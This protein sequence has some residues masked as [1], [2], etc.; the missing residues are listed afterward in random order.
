MPTPTKHIRLT[1]DGSPII[2]QD[3]SSSDKR[4]E[5][6]PGPAVEH[7]E[8]QRR[9]AGRAPRPR[10]PAARFNRSDSLSVETLKELTDAPNAVRNEVSRRQNNVNRAAD[11]RG[12]VASLRDDFRPGGALVPE[13]NRP[14]RWRL[15]AGS[16]VVDLAN[17]PGVSRA[18]TGGVVGPL[19]FIS[20]MVSSLAWPALVLVLVLIMRKP[21]KDLFSN[22]RR[23]KSFAAGATG[24]RIEYALE[25]AQTELAKAQVERPPLLPPPSVD[26]S[27][28]AQQGPLYE[29]SPPAAVLESFARLE[30]ALRQA[31][32]EHPSY[33]SGGS[34]PRSTRQ[35]IR[36]AVQLD[37]LSEPEGKAFEELAQIRNYTAHGE[38]EEITEGAAQRFTEI[39]ADL[40]ASISAWRSAHPPLRDND[41]HV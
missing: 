17:L 18:N 41:S 15:G 21:L 3:D 6:H 16:A 20:S 27:P 39:A 38:A 36:R 8:P 4:H 32:R 22:D 19:Q 40:M 12:I 35:L 13:D 33:L 24:L 34:Q 37:V 23:M 28:P 30:Q 10:A 11:A 26:A 14:S 2:T 29:V 7:H 1:A 5:P 9:R 25:E 31:L